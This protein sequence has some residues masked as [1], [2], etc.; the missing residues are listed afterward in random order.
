[1][2]APA[3]PIEQGLCMRHVQHDL[4]YTVEL[5]SRE[6][7]RRLVW[8]LRRRCDAGQGMVRS[9]RAREAIC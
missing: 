9:R 2:H 3:R 6:G 4:M 5:K 8:R 7:G 1:M